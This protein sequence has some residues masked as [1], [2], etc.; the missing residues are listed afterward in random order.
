MLQ[1]VTAVFTGCAKTA[2]SSGKLEARAQ[3]LRR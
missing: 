3:V 2:R 1:A